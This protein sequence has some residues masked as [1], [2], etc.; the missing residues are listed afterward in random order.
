MQAEIKT[1]GPL[2]TLRE[3]AK[4]I[5]EILGV[6][7]AAIKAMRSRTHRPMPRTSEEAALEIR[8]FY[9]ANKRWP[10]KG[11]GSRV[12]RIFCMVRESL[13]KAGAI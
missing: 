12:W 6:D 9:R 11:D 7:E 8:E 3:R 10:K 4:T 2:Q 1:K 13:E 5:K